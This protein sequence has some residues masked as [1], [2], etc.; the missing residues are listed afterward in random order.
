MAIFTVHRPPDADGHDGAE[1]TVFIRERMS[2]LALIFGPLWILW[3]RLWLVFVLWALAVGTIV[4]VDL[5]ASP[6]AATILAVLFALWFALV[7]NDARRWT[8]ERNG[9]TL[10]GIVHADDADDAERHYFARL[11]AREAPRA[12][13]QAPVETEPRAAGRTVIPGG[14]LPPVVGFPEARV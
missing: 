3:H 9:W 14:G 8:L 2:W 13:G 1:R 5:L 7:A 10:A 11:A 4:A 12:R 6:I